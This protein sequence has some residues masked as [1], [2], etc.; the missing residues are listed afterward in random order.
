MLHLFI[1]AAYLKES[2]RVELLGG[3][4]M[5]AAILALAFGMHAM[6]FVQCVKGSVRRWKKRAASDKGS[7]AIETKMVLGVHADAKKA[8]GTEEGKEGVRFLDLS[9]LE[10]IVEPSPLRAQAMPLYS[11]LP[12]LHQFISVTHKSG[13]GAD[14]HKMSSSCSELGMSTR[15]STMPVSSRSEMR[16]RDTATPASSIT[17]TPGWRSSTPGSGLVRS[18]STIL[19]IPG[20]LP[21]PSPPPHSSPTT[22]IPSNPPTQRP[23]FSRLTS[24]ER[25]LQTLQALRVQARLLRAQAAASA[26]LARV[27]VDRMPVR[28]RGLYDRLPDRRVLYDYVGLNVGPH[29]NGVGGRMPKEVRA[30]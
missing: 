29:G 21:P 5:P 28:I 2:N 20:A 25:A 30:Y 12:D 10:V 15:T 8:K 22:N 3:S 6:W 18:S 24:V 1:L 4:L 16:T 7:N 9:N 27:P 19:N 26:A 17:Y 14:E 11:S 13:F 23:P